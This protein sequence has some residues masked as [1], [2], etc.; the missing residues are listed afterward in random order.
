MCNLKVNGGLGI[1]DIGIKNKA[2]LNKWVLRYGKKP[3]AMWRVIIASK[4]GGN[5]SDLLPFLGL[6]RRFSGIWKNITKVMGSQDFQV[7]DLS[8]CVGFSL[9]DG[10]CIRFW[11]DDWIGGIVLK[12]A[13][14][15]IFALSINK[16]GKVKEFGFWSNYAWP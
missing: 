11:E 4:Y 15:R 8:S 12:Y 9:G 5:F 10:G 14:P 3:N 6:Q 1:V 16:L 13:F 2:L 7:N